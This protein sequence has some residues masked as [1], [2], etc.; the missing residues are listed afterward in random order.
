MTAK[1]AIKIMLAL[2]AL[3]TL[4]HL[5]IV[6]KIIPYDITWGGRLQNDGEMYAFESVS[7]I[8]NLLLMVVLLVK[9]NYIKPVIPSK[10]VNIV[11]WIF[12]VLFGLNTV[13]NLFAVSYFEK[14]FSAVTLGFCV[15]IW[16][17]LKS[18]K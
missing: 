3:I 4:F 1:T 18:K 8:I 14:A 9:G 7:I 12:L 5:M 2:L 16:I 17:I 10:V 13:G 6:L 11:L 15:L